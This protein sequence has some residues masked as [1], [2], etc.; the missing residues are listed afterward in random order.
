MIHRRRAHIMALAPNTPTLSPS[1]LS[2][3]RA[4]IH[5]HENLIT[6]TLLARAL[7]AILEEASVCGRMR[8]RQMREKA[9]LTITEAIQV[10]LYLHRQDV[11]QE[12]IDGAR[13]VDLSLARA[14]LSLLAPGR[15]ALPREATEEGHSFTRAQIAWGC[16][17]ARAGRLT[18]MRVA[19]PSRWT[20][21]LA[22]ALGLDLS[23]TPDA[24]LFPTSRA[25]RL[26]DLITGM[27]EQEQARYVQWAESQLPADGSSVVWRNRGEHKGLAAPSSR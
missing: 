2:G 13:A 11:L 8:A 22:R 6:D 25:K 1:A 27:S 12:E 26:C 14:Y 10:V 15:R 16:M 18:T 17:H 20:R 4:T 5:Q 21:G 9:K 19:R 3:K 7:E 24:R 23:N